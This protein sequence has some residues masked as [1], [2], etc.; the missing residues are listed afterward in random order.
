MSGD[1]RG[2]AL[3]PGQSGP[4]QLVGVGPV[5][6]GTGRADRSPAV[7][8]RQVDHLIR[9]LLRIERGEDLP[10]VGI[11]VADG[12]A[13]PDR[14]NASPGRLGP[15]QPLVI[16]VTSS[17]LEQLGVEGPSYLA[18]DQRWR[19]DHRRNAHP[20]A[21]LLQRGI[22]SAL[23]GMAALRSFTC[24]V[25]S[26]GELPHEV[27][28]FRWALQA[29]DCDGMRVQAAISAIEHQSSPRRGTPSGRRHVKPLAALTAANSRSAACSRLTKWASEP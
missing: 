18:V 15:R 14:A 23:T 25:G 1:R 10:G 11:D 28:Y 19:R 16:V 17:T 20:S 6:R 4:D 5:G 2:H 3:A 21:H 22:D 7:P 27:V 8:V 26:I 9:D 24:W 29:P 12:A 13:Q